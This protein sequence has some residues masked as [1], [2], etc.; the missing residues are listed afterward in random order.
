MG[1]LQR[2]DERP[3]GRPEVSPTCHRRTRALISNAARSCCFVPRRVAAAPLEA[4][5]V[6]LPPGGCITRRRYVFFSLGRVK[7][8]SPAIGFA[9]FFLFF[10][11]AG[12]RRAPPASESDDDP[13]DEPSDGAAE[14]SGAARIL[15]FAGGAAGAAGGASA[16]LRGWPRGRAGGASSALES[17]AVGGAAAS[18]SGAAA[19]L[20]PRGAT[21]SHR[22]AAASQVAGSPDRFRGAR[23]APHGGPGLIRPQRGLQPLGLRLVRLRRPRGHDGLD[24]PVAPR[25]HALRGALVGLRAAAREPQRAAARAAPALRRRRAPL[26]RPRLPQRTLRVPAHRGSGPAE[27][28]VPIPQGRRLRRRHRPHAREKV[29]ETGAYAP[30][31]FHRPIGTPEFRNSSTRRLSISRASTRN[32]GQGS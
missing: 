20:R 12:L 32:S 13:A 19:L 5:A 29:P 8:S 30:D 22:P 11:R 25:G 10:F 14:W 1:K 7:P 4:A 3:A 31:I 2:A 28:D 9:R 23:V 16:L 26:E 17:P 27:H 21:S 15:R 6:G 24:G 18:G